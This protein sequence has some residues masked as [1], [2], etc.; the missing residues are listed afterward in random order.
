MSR[1]N[2]LYQKEVLPKFA[3]EFTVGNSMA[4]PKLIKININLGIGTIMKNK[5]AVDKVIKEISIICGQRPNERKTKISVASFGTREGA[6]VGLGLTLRKKRMNDFFD[7]LVSI[8]L[9]RLR[10]FRG[11]SDISFDKY[12]NY[13]LGIADYTVFP[14]VD[15]SKN[16]V[17]HGLEITFVTKAGSKEKGKRLL[18]LMGMP[19]M[20]NT[21]DKKENDK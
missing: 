7:R 17:S 6:V 3:D 4:V 14:E 11:V 20:K 13:T 8:V 5:E 19:F 15:T 21:N 10:D 9:P 16:I 18:E 12:G 1:I 2:D